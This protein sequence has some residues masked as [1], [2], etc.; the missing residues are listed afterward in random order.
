MLQC[1]CQKGVLTPYVNAGGISVD[2]NLGAAYPLSGVIGVKSML[3]HLTGEFIFNLE[4]KIH[5]V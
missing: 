3:V 2:K 1:P 5:K 4:Y